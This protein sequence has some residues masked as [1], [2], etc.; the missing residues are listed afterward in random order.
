MAATIAVVLLRIHH[1]TLG[2][3]LFAAFVC[4]FQSRERRMALVCTVSD[5]LV[6]EVLELEVMVL[7]VFWNEGDLWRW[8]SEES[9]DDEIIG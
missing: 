4:M 3:N 9:G 6:R 5:V 8:L 2:G 1:T 7:K